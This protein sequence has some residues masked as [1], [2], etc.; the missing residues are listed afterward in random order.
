MLFLEAAECLDHYLEQAAES[1]VEIWVRGAGGRESQDS[2][3]PYLK[4]TGTPEQHKIRK[5]VL[6]QICVKDFSADML[7]VNRTFWRQLFKFTCVSCRFCLNIF[8]LLY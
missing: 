6:I 8:G 4:Q 5:L 3:K 2:L 7:H 1:V